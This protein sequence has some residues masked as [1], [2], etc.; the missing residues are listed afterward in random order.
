MPRSYLK[1]SPAGAGTGAAQVHHIIT[2]VTYAHVETKI[3][4]HIRFRNQCSPKPTA[5]CSVQ[6]DNYVNVLAA[7]RVRISTGCICACLFKC[8]SK[9]R[10]T[11][12]SPHVLCMLQVA[13]ICIQQTITFYRIRSQRQS[14]VQTRSKITTLLATPKQLLR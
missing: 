4:P 2:Q 5:C 9:G 7:P 13:T 10:V 6:Q 1:L 8:R 11:I 3:W 12:H 14:A